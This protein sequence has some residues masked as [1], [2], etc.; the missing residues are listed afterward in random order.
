MRRRVDIC[1]VSG[2]GGWRGGGG[3]GAGCQLAAQL[4][5]RVCEN[6]GSRVLRTTRI[7]FQVV[8]KGKGTRAI[9]AK[10]IFAKWQAVDAVLT[11]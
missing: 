2:G 11:V 1:I 9:L 4:R 10:Q 7:A 6:P 8:P 5:M 3:E